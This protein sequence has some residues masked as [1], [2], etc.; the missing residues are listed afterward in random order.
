MRAP[1][2]TAEPFCFVHT[3]ARSACETQ[4][5]QLKSNATKQDATISELKKTVGVLMVQLK[6]PGRTNPESERT[7]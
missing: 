1:R 4:F 2:E 7:A 3:D 5:G 6:D